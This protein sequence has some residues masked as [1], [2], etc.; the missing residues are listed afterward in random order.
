MFSLTHAGVRVS[1]GQSEKTQGASRPR[2][3]PEKAGKPMARLSAEEKA[4]LKRLM[5]EAEQE[6]EEAEPEKI[7]DQV[8]DAGTEEVIVFRGNAAAFK[9]AFGFAAPEAPKNEEAAKEPTEEAAEAEESPER[10]KEPKAPSR[11]RYFG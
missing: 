5:E 4:L 6:Q 10:K 7:A 9:K 1:A 2:D 8:D 11:S 3:R